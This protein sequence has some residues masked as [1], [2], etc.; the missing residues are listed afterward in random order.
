MVLYLPALA[1]EHLQPRSD[2][3]PAEP[4]V[5]TKEVRRVLVMD[6]EPIVRVV[7]TDLLRTAG[8][9]VENCSNGDEALKLAQ[10]AKGTFRAYDAILL[11]L[12]VA[13]GPGGRQVV[14]SLRELLPQALLIA[15]SGYHDDQVIC[16]PKRFGFDSS[17]RKPYT[18][19]ELK[20]ALGLD[21][22]G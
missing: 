9:E 10:E 18:Y 4:A 6:D 13:D 22:L 15:S 5:Q 17:L 2:E 8:L 11:D 16:D 1:A 12:N 3:R 14:S 21:S 19:R 7:A 20:T